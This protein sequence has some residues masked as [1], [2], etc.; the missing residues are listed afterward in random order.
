MDQD[1]PHLLGD[2]REG[3]PHHLERDRVERHTRSTTTAPDAWTAPR[4]PGSMSAVASRP[5]RIAGPSSVTPTARSSRAHRDAVTRLPPLPLPLPNATGR[6]PRDT[7]APPA[8]APKRGRVASPIA[9]TRRLTSSTG[10]PLP[11]WPNRSRCAAR[12][13]SRI[14]R[15][16]FVVTGI[17]TSQPC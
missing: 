8:L 2:R 15:G 4:H 9:T 10:W 5:A 1:E 13:A 17:V 14:C 6:S 11:E 12:N 16:L 3:V 7:L